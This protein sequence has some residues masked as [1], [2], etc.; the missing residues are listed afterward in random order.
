MV[1][2]GRTAN[3]VW[4]QTIKDL[5]NDTEIQ[6]SRIGDTKELLHV[7]LRITDPR[8][9]WLTSRQPAINPAFALAEVIWILNGREDA[10]F[11]NYWNRQLPK[12]SGE[13][14]CYHGA[15]GRRL[16]TKFGFDQLERAYFALLNNPDSR[17]VNLQI[18]DPCTD[19]PDHN[20]KA[21][22]EDI[23]CNVSA[24]LKVRKGRL[25]WMQVVRS[26]D[27]MLGLPYNIIQFT[28]LQ[29]VMAGWLGLEVGSYNQLSD[30]LHMYVRD[31]PRFAESDSIEL[32]ENTDQLNLPKDVSDRAFSEL[33]RVLEYII[34]SRCSEVQLMETITS[35]D[36]PKPHRNMLHIIGAEEARRNKWHH[37]QNQLISEIS[38]PL[39]IQIW[40]EWAWKR[41]KS[42]TTT[43]PI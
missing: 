1:Y 10:E 24:F 17:Q 34:R 18:W 3:D 26:N 29:E 7:M 4:I 8:Q 15:Y 40:N 14:D 33:E 16:R 25:E 38:N 41:L 2:E 6:G 27:V 19:F 36:L 20:G 23:P 42:A 39:L 37:A 13:S 21:V 12:Y 31:I 30:S 43:A 35:A 5:R 9:R 28:T 22:A 11:L 32:H